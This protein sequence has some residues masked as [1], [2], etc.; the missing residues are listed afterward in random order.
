VINATLYLWLYEEVAR[1]LYEAGEKNC[2][3]P[4]VNGSGKP[5]RQDDCHLP[6]NQHAVI[7]YQIER[8]RNYNVMAQL[9]ES[10]CF[11]V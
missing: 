6:C 9:R 11:L 5:E 4:S 8:R 3:M 2:E 10:A 7:A 1:P